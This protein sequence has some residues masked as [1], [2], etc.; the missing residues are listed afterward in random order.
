[1]ITLAILCYNGIGNTKIVYSLL[2]KQVN[3]KNSIS[4]QEALEPHYIH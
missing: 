4:L 3:Y 2:D 1:M